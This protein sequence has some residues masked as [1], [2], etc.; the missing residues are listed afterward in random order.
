MCSRASPA[1]T[2]DVQEQAPYPDLGECPQDI[3]LFA[4]ASYAPVYL[5][6]GDMLERLGPS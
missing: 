3:T 5:A 4:K 2:A 1:P 6:Q